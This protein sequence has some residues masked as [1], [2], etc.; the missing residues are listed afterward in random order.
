MYN[1]QVIN[2]IFWPKNVHSIGRQAG[3]G[4]K[5]VFEVKP[6]QGSRI[7]GAVWYQISI[8]IYNLTL[9]FEVYRSNQSNG[10]TDKN[11]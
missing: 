3:L 10:T 9:P 2:Y 1:F 11:V 5:T 4:V 7:F 8:Y 6:D